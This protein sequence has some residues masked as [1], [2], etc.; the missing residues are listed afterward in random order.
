[1]SCLQRNRQFVELKHHLYTVHF[2]D[3]IIAKLPKDKPYICPIQSCS[4]QEN[5]LKNLILHYIGK[6]H[7]VLQT[8]VA[9]Y[10]ENLTKTQNTNLEVTTYPDIKSNI[11]IEFQDQIPSESSSILKTK[12]LIESSTDVPTNRNISK[13][14]VIILAENSVNIFKCAICDKEFSSQKLLD[15][16]M[17]IVHVDELINQQQDPAENEE[18]SISTK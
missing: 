16:H 5:N 7:R 1:M 2:K 18:T 9:E 10:L 8:S 4:T 12:E 17:N 13:S 3:Q 15:M 6:G 14:T 11:K